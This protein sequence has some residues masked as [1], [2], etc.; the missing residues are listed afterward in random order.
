MQQIK[1]FLKW[2]LF[3]S[4]KNKAVIIWNNKREISEIKFQR[5]NK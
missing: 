3:C 5:K 2:K 1:N 4:R